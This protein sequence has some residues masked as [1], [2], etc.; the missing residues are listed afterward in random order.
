MSSWPLQAFSH[1]PI[2]I[3]FK[4]TYNPQ[5]KELNICFI[6]NA[7]FTI[8]PK[9]GSPF[10]WTIPYK[11]IYSFVSHHSSILDLIQ[12]PL[13]HTRT[14]HHMTH[15]LTSSQWIFR[16]QYSQFCSE[17]PWTREYQDFE[18]LLFINSRTKFL[19][20]NNCNGTGSLDFG[21]LEPSF[22]YFNL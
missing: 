7:N 2:G 19:K 10:F 5:T 13:L 16:F 21:M 8:F 15:A 18:N 9:D 20:D 11:G 12:F 17:G 1:V 22:N 4:I 6:G 14:S 3:K